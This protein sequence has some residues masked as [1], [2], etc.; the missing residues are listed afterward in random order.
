MIEIGSH[1][2]AMGSSFAAGPGIKPLTDHAALQSGRNYPHLVSKSLGLLLTD[3]TC[4]GATTKNLF[5]KPQLGLGKLFPPQ[6]KAVAE[7]TALVTITVGG[8]DL[9]FISDVTK[10][11]VLAR[12]VGW[13]PFIRDYLPNPDP[14]EREDPRCDALITAMVELVEAIRER[15]PQTL[16][17]ITDYL[18]V[19]GPDIGNWSPRL[20]PDHIDALRSLA[21]VQ[22]YAMRQVCDWTDSIF[23]E[24]SAASVE[25]G[26]GSSEPWVTG[27]TM[28]IPFNGGVVPFHPTIEGMQAVADLIITKVKES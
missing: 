26:L 21:D 16:I 24:A 6:L 7:D 13:V 14:M 18:T 8:N 27:L 3:A 9:G 23:I 17:A 11:A 19:V 1:Y 15:A 25:H 20:E 22:S 12:T 5:D 10:L 2:V 4:S 28:G